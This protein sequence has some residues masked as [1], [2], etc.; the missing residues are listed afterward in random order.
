MSE[1]KKKLS[2][3]N[4]PSMF[5]YNE[6]AQKQIESLVNKITPKFNLNDDLDI[7]KLLT[8]KCR[9][10]LTKACLFHDYLIINVVANLLVCECARI[11]Y[12]HYHYVEINEPI[13]LFF[14]DMKDSLY[15]YL[16]KFHMQEE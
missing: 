4:E 10:Y 1:N 13:E 16:K 12:K 7:I 9:E 6:E 14:D 5:E 2:I 3:E 15:E 8:N 11:L